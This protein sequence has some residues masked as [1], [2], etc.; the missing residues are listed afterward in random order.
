MRSKEHDKDR[1][2]QKIVATQ[3]LTA[4]ITGHV[5]QTAGEKN[6]FNIAKQNSSKTRTPESS[7]SMTLV[8]SLCDGVLKETSVFLFLPKQRV[9]TQ[10]TMARKVV[11][12]SDDFMNKAQF[13]TALRFDG[14]M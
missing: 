10:K 13:L 6:A 11:L 7:P 5:Y 12:F 9:C 4:A 14:W 2:K 8:S 1:N 3:N